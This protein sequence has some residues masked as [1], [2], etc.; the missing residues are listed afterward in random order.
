M[1]HTNNQHTHT[2]P[3][4]MQ[5]TLR[6]INNTHIHQPSLDPQNH[7]IGIISV[8]FRLLMHVYPCFT[9]VKC[10]VLRCLNSS[11]Q[12]KAIGQQGKDDVENIRRRENKLG[13]FV[14]E[15]KFVVK[16]VARR[17][18]VKKMKVF[19]VVNMSSLMDT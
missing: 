12:D 3:H 5:D 17:L 19:D 8:T 9:Q 2:G 1:H 4:N 15:Y 7:S 18:N 6:C 13:T 10:Q 16:N 11:I 14:W